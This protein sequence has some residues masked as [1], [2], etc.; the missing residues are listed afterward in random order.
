M[1]GMFIAVYMDDILIYGGANQAEHKRLVQMV[2]ET[3]HHHCLS[4]KAAK[5]A[6][7]RQPE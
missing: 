1:L 3:L 2:L 4:A 6:F 7:F 5:C